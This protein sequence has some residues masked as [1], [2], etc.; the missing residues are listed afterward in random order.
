MDTKSGKMLDTFSMAAA[1]SDGGSKI[2]IR[3]RVHLDLLDKEEKTGLEKALERLMLLKRHDRQKT[4][5]E[6]TSNLGN[7]PGNK[8][9]QDIDGNKGGGQNTK[10][11][12]GEFTELKIAEIQSYAMDHIKVAGWMCNK[13]LGTDA[14]NSRSKLG[15]G[16]LRDLIPSLRLN[17]LTHKAAGRSKGYATLR[18]PVTDCPIYMPFGWG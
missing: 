16:E 8:I 5:I 12:P 9:Q 17:G 13:R 2:L 15:R 3:I 14:R 1:G 18:G 10:K 11:F 4:E 7:K 6:L